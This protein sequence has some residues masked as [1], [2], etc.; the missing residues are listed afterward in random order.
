MILWTQHSLTL[1]SCFLRYSGRGG[2][3]NE[4]RGNLQMRGMASAV[5][6]EYLAS[7]KSVKSKVVQR[8]VTQVQEKGGRF[9]KRDSATKLWCEISNEQARKKVAQALRDSVPD[10]KVWEDLE[11]TFETLQEKEH[12]KVGNQVAAREEAS[13]LLL[14]FVEPQGEKVGLSPTE[15]TVN[16]SDSS[17]I[18]LELDSEDEAL[19][20][21]SMFPEHMEGPK[22]TEE[23]E[24]AEMNG[25]TEEERLSVL[26]DIFGDSCEITRPKK[27]VARGAKVANIH[28]LLHDMRS[29]IDATP[30][31]RKGAL[32][33]AVQKGR[34]DEFSDSRM[35]L[36]L[37]R[38]DMNAKV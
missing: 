8:V 14:P 15:V 35:E 28:S 18:D 12:G 3:V 16:S 5:R 26:T 34:L 1:A 19:L 6:Q 22:F 36:F 13:M 23:Q 27:K 4:H 17:E 31:E 9:L 29:E 32:V 11:T 30:I 33:E 21:V 10:K 38:E 20:L 2:D 24:L 25:M 37:I 7:K